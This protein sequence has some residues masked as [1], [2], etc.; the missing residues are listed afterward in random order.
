M[1]ATTTG[2]LGALADPAG[3]RPG[4]GARWE[5]LRQH[6]L[7]AGAGNLLDFELLEGLLFAG[8]PR[9]NPEPVVKVLLRQFGS[10]AEVLNADTAALAAG[11]GL[12]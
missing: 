2:K 3:A 1:D 6:L 9:G 8:S 7:A 10:F 12:L 5:Q 11:L 4:A